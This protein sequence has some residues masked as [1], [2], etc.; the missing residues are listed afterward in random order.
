[1]CAILVALGLAEDWKQAEKMIKEKRPFIKMNSLHRKSLEEWSKHLISTKR[2]S[3]ST[4]TNS[5][6]ASILSDYIHKR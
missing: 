6:A 1:M 4:S 5:D 2:S 3:T